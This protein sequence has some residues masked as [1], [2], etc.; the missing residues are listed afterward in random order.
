MEDIAALLPTEKPQQP[1]QPQQPQHHFSFSYATPE[2]S[3]TRTVSPQTSTS[4]FSYGSPGYIA[5]QQAQQPQQPQQP[6]HTSPSIRYY[7]GGVYG[8][9]SKRGVIPQH[10]QQPQQP[11]HAQHA[12]QSQH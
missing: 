2:R 10:A 1:Q 12:Q 6:Q 4:Q 11:Q 9:D 7:G 8:Q 3:Q 5:Q